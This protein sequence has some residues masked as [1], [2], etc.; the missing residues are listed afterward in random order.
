M[1][2]SAS[3]FLATKFRAFTP[4]GLVPTGYYLHS[5]VAGSSTPQ[6]TYT[7]ST[8]TVANANP[9]ALDAY[10]Q[11]QVWLKAGLSYKLQVRAGATLSSTLIEEV[12]YVIGDN[13]VILIDALI[14][15]LADTSTLAKGDALI[16]VKQNLTGSKAMTQ[17]SFNAEWVTATQFTGVDSTGVA[18]S[19]DGLIACL[20]S[21][22]KHIRIPAGTYKITK[23]LVVPPGVTVYG[24]GLDITVIDGSGAAYANLTSGTLM[25]CT[26][27]TLDA[28]AAL[29]TDIAKNDRSISFGAAHGLVMDDV[30]V[31]YNDNDYSYSGFRSYYKAGEMFQVGYVTGTTDVIARGCACDA[32]DKD[33]VNVYKLNGK[34]VH[35]KDFTLKGVPAE[36]SAN[37]GIRVINGINCSVSNVRVSGSGYA[38]I[39]FYRCWNTHFSNVICQE[40][41]QAGTGD[42]YGLV[43]SNCQHFN[44]EGG[45]FSARNHGITTGGSSADGDVPCRYIKIYN[46]HIVGQGNVQAFSFHGHSE[47]MDVRGC[48]M[49]GG[50]TGGGDY[51]N[52]DNCVLKGECNNGDII[53]YASE[54]RGL[55]FNLT[56][57]T[58]YNNEVNTSRGIFVDIGGNSDTISNYTKKGGTINIHGNTFVAD[59]ALEGVAYYPIKI[60][61]L[62]YDGAEEIGI[63]ITN[64][65]LQWP[66]RGACCDIRVYDRTVD[67]VL[68]TGRPWDKI[69]FKNNDF[70]GCGGLMLRNSGA[71]DF[72]AKKVY[73]DGNTFRSAYTMSDVSTVQDYVSCKGNSWYGS[74][75]V[76]I[77]INST[78]GNETHLVHFDGNTCIEGSESR[79]ATASSQGSAIFTNLSKMVS[80]NNV[81]GSR[82]LTVPVD[83]NSGFVVG[84]IITGGSSS[85]TATVAALE[86]GTTYI[87]ILNSMVGTFT[88]GE[89]ITGT[90]SAV[91]ATLS[92]AALLTEVIAMYYG[93]IT[94]L[95]HGGN[96]NLNS[97]S[98]SLNSI[99][100]EHDMDA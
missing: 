40:D 50:L 17:H 48:L 7:D 34:A 49:D 78:S 82:N 70:D 26:A 57:C 99:G 71:G 62:G 36:A 33:Y 42:E 21:G 56:N 97:D 65:K 25:L 84:E 2:T 67:T 75:G 85:A 95:W 8:A 43:I 39:E 55:N 6:A 19:S 53:L 74:K 32:Y 51:I 4:A 96:A 80:R 52:I 22:A 30:F 87:S 61:N 1:A 13:Y 12:D 60:N 94:E 72:A 77:S 10:G 92:G 98:D 44:V 88:S 31:V 76:S 93:S 89:V 16:G 91:T 63:K 41:Y 100:T 24:D 90:S 45:Y 59:N 28:I 14:A 86:P 15:D 38:G 69:E 68:H 64:N 81:T 27:G 3:P 5:F 11:S 20:A 29:D 37:I 73:Y 79:S 83:S 18:D 66:G 58:I 9:L 35:F 23:T 47:Y 54:F 46:A